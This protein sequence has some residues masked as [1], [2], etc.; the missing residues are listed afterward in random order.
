M[1]QKQKM[2][3]HQYF[4]TEWNKELKNVRVDENNKMR[5]KFEFLFVNILVF[6]DD[7]AENI[8]EVK[9]KIKKL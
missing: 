5:T 2:F 1:T 7:L 9:K 3:Y 6:A 8:D 4:L